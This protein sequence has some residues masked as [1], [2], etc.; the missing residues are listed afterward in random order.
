MRKD[1]VLQVLGSLWCGLAAAL[2]TAQPPSLPPQMLDDAELTDVFFL[3]PDRGWAVGD[4]GVILSTTDGG[5]HWQPAD[6][7]VNCRLESVRFVDENLG[8][9]VGGWTHPYSHRSS[10]VVLRTEDGG[11][12][13]TKMPAATLPALRTVRF[14][15]AKHGW[16]IGTPSAMYPSGVFRTEDGGRSW[17]SLPAEQPRVWLAG[18]FVSQQ[19]G[20]VVGRKGASAFASANTLEP[21]PKPDT[22]L[23]HARSLA[24]SPRGELWVAG[25]GGLLMKAEPGGG[26][27]ST[28]TLSLPQ[29]VLSAVDFRAFVLRGGH[30]WVAGNP[31]SFLL[32]SLDAGQTWQLLHT[33]EPCPINAL[34]FLNEQHGWAVGAFGTIL[35]TRDG[36]ETW[37]RQRSGGERAAV[38]A[39]I[40]EPGRLPLEALTTLCGDEG[41][42]GAVEVIGR[43]DV[44]TSSSYAAVR[45]QRTANGLSLLGVSQSNQAWQFPLRQPGLNPST[46]AVA[47]GWNFVHSG[48]GRKRLDE[49]LTLRIRQW[50]PDVVITRAHQA[51]DADHAARLIGLAILTA[52]ERAA[53]PGVY[54]DHTRIL[55]LQPW[56][57]RKVL[58]A[59]PEESGDITLE[60]TRLATQ[61][62]KSIRDYTVAAR[63]LIAENW[64]PP[65][66]RIG[67]DLLL[68]DIPRSVATRDLAGGLL[69]APGSD[70][71]RRSGSPPP[72]SLSSLRLASRRQETVETL[73]V[74]AGDGT[75]S[76]G[77]LA[78]QLD[79]LTRDLKARDG[80]ALLFQL[81]QAYRD[82]G[83]YDLAAASS[84]Q[85]AMS[86]PRH[87]LTEPALVWLL[88]Y[89]ASGEAMAVFGGDSESDSKRRDRTSVAAVF[90]EAL[91]PGLQRKATTTRFDS[92]VQRAGFQS[93]ELGANIRL[94]ELA[95]VIQ[96]TRLDLFA[97]P[98]VRMAVAAAHRRRGEMHSARQLYQQVASGQP[99]G[100]WRQTARAELWFDSRRG[101]CPKPLLTCPTSAAKPVLDAVLDDSIWKSS[102]QVTLRSKLGDDE[103]WPASVMLARDDE[104]LYLATVCQK[105]AGLEYP[106][107]E[108]PRPRDPDLTKHD[109]VELLIDVDRDYGSF[110]R[111]TID[112]RGWTGEACWNDSRWNPT[113]HVASTNDEQSWTVEAAIPLH[114]LAGGEATAGASWSIGLQRIV[115]GIGFQSWT[116]PASIAGQPE[117]FGYLTL[118]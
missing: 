19:Q 102:T 107:T 85:L 70:A 108:G 72:L 61:F 115:P 54:P 35:A 44:E 116:Q 33:N 9:A 50:R 60:S 68:T 31:G 4:R 40:D 47:E 25:D 13:W 12:R 82:L 79:V 39:F 28:P 80:A 42:L 105:A 16:A 7:P 101:R 51:D 71:R 29:E 34:T 53:D 3:D 22:G 43:R 15:G 26:R 48:D 24:V 49:Y 21:I 37:I 66:R 52:A 111:L 30:C 88:S 55:G 86:Y 91:P 1:T 75:H 56:R 6:S 11:R 45:E 32:R 87:A 98:T 84:Q 100:A 95:Q 92:R 114:Q 112:H 117:G 46:A 2:A 5:R 67:F 18:E 76:H 104:Y 63:A 59:T 103:T 110:Y 17:S 90:N 8:W 57:V 113:W 118:E 14:F 58:A 93:S 97:E 83:R 27:W 81:A 96:R 73:L 64:S 10:G 65:P 109:R 69:I 36:G 41:Y 77:E 78:A 99:R 106:S 89:R 23:R 74:H 62:G 38:V 94:E 20:F